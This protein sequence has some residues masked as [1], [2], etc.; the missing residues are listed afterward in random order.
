MSDFVFVS[1]L[2]VQN[3]VLLQN[4]FA[5]IAQPVEQLPFKQRV[6]GSS[7]SRLTFHFPAFSPFHGPLRRVLARLTGLCAKARALRA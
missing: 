4:N 6:D 1:R 2:L 3:L 7:P 5:P